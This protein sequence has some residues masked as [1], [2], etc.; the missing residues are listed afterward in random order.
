MGKMISDKDLALSMFCFMEDYGGERI[1]KAI[2]D[3]CKIVAEQADKDLDG[4]SRDI[5]MKA[6][7]MIHDAA[8]YLAEN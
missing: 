6:S 4:T 2:S 7:H 1:I 3:A 5:Y 8:E